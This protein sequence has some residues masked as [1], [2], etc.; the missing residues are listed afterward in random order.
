M[1]YKEGGVLT[2]S[3]SL[4]VLPIQIFREG[5]KVRTLGNVERLCSRIPILAPALCAAHCGASVSRVPWYVW[6]HKKQDGG[7]SFIPTKQVPP[8]ARPCDVLVVGPFGAV[9]SYEFGAW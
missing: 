8:D 5:P 2:L 7:V 9:A 1:G 3:A 6:P 4:Y